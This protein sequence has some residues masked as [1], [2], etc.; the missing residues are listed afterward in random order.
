MLAKSRSCVLNSYSSL[1]DSHVLRAAAG[2]SARLLL[3]VAPSLAN[4]QSFTFHGLGRPEP[5]AASPSPGSLAA[6]ARDAAGVPVVRFAR[7]TDRGQLPILVTHA[8]AESCAVRVPKIARR[9][10]C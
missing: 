4:A 10:L 8:K 9:F 2:M 6:I 5:S 1:A 7:D 3:I